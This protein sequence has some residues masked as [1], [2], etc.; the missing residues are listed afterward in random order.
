VTLPLDAATQAAIQ[1][2]TVLPRDFLWISAKNRVTG[3]LVPHGMWSDAGSVT[4]E[5]IDPITDTAVARP[6][7]GA[8]GLISIS[9]VQRSLGLT[10]NTVQIVLSQIDPQAE[11]IIRGLEPKYARVELFRGWLDPVSRLLVAPAR[12]R[13]VGFLDGAPIVTPAEGGEGS[14]SLTCASYTQEF[15]RSNTSKRS[16][17]DQRL[18]DPNDAFFQHVA[19]VGDWEINW[20]VPDPEDDGA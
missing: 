1:A 11:Q 3:A 8:G 15:T 12:A 14:I 9:D 6:W 10:V 18:R 19:T 4:A 2:G 17:A 16:D 13:F 20:G 5:V 7:E